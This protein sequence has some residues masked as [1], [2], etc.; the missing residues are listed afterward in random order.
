MI[1]AKVLTGGNGQKHIQLHSK[2]F[3]PLCNL[4]LLAKYWYTFSEVCIEQ[5]KQYK[6]PLYLLTAVSKLLNP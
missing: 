5:T 3:N 1:L 6:M 4:G 2:L